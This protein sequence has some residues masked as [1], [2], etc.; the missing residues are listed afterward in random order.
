MRVSIVAPAASER[1]ARQYRLF[2]GQGHLCQIYAPRSD[3]SSEPAE[4]LD[5]E[6]VGGTA[7]FLFHYVDG[8][9]PLLETMHQ[10][11]HGLVVLDLCDAAA[12]EKAPVH[13]ADLCLVADGVQKRALHEET[14]CTL[15]RIYV[16]SDQQDYEENLEVIVD[17]AMQGLPPRAAET[18]P[19][20]GAETPAG[21]GL[22]AILLIRDLSLDREAILDRVYRAMQRRQTAG[23]YGPDV[24]TLGPEALRPMPLEDDATDQVYTSLLRF[25]TALDDL[26]A[27]S[28]LQEPDFHSLVPLLG[29]LIVA[30]RRFWNWM[31]AKWYVRGWMG[32]Q[33]AFNAQVVGVL[34][35]L[36]Q[37]QESDERRIH[38]LERLL[39]D[40]ESAL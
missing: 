7:L 40:E 25:Q 30:V 14:G 11:Q 32:Q 19:E 38:E 4:F 15:D 5:L 27:K 17:Q 36:L 22:E 18:R 3:G 8:M 35:E 20:P 34:S 31:A 12:P 37:M 23:G 21:E 28:R 10:L 29:P 2:T 13:Y 6:H 16:L 26:A 24:T 33:M 9:Y 39:R 1:A